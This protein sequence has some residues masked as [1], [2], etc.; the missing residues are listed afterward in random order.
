MKVAAVCEAIKDYNSNGDA[1]RVE[2]ILVHTGQHY[3]ANMSDLFFN[4]LELPKPDLFLGVGSSSHSAQIARVMERFERVLLAEKPD[5]VVV[6]GDVNSTIAC[7]LV[8]KKTWC[9]GG[10]CDRDFIPKLAHVEAGLRSFDRT[11]PEE[12]NRIVT[13][14]IADYLFTTEESANENL[15][16][17]GIPENK[18]HFVGN[19]MID[20]LLRYRSKATESAIL[21]DLQLDEGGQV[22][23]YAILTLHRPTNVDDA[24]TF[25]RIIQS[26]LDVSRHMQIIFPAHPRT[27][28]QIQQADLGDYFVDH[29]MDGPEPWD[30]RV[31][32]RLIPPLGYLDFLQLMSHARVVLT[33]SGGIQEETTILGVPCITLRNVTER[34]VTLT[35][36]TNVLVGA[37]PETIIRAFTRVLQS[38]ARLPAPPPL[39]DGNAAKRIVQI[40]AQAGESV[41]PQPVPR[42]PAPPPAI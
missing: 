35:H 2:H 8:T 36:G 34:P 19:V 41:S 11:M 3:D 32:I 27:L 1:P 21:T 33:D 15:G 4:D 7:A 24:R 39:W 31:R 25:S 9:S 10:P 5:V 18:I 13:D 14:S 12:V 23:P 20:T 40:L 38:S 42:Q 16:A 26:F 37:D 17:E 6:V 29:F 30:S 22:R 28:K